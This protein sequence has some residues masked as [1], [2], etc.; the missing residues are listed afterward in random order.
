[1]G[2]TPNKPWSQKQKK[3]II[4]GLRKVSRHREKGMSVA[5]PVYCEPSST[6][7]ITIQASGEEATRIHEMKLAVA[8]TDETAV[9]LL[10]YV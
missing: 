2:C 4:R 10:L 9:R 5:S 8:Y 6:S 7:A 3:D 1:M